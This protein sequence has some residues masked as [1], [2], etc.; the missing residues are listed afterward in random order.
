MHRHTQQQLRNIAIIAHVDHGKT[1]LVD[2]MLKQ[3]RTFAA[4]QKENQQTTI[5]DSNDLERERGVT[6]LAKNTAVFWEDYKINILDTPGHADFSGEVER[7]LN[8]ADGCVLLVDAAEGVLS[9]TRFVLAL[10]LQLGLVPIVV[11]NKVDRKDQRVA[12]VKSEID[13]LFLELATNEAQLSF[14]LLYA[15]GFEGI[16]GTQLAEQSDHSLKITNSEDLSPVF[17]TIIET[18][19]FPKGDLAGP[20]QLQVT[21]VDYD[22]YQGKY[23]IGRIV[24]GSIK[25]GQQVALLRSETESS[26]QKVK[27]LFTY[28]GLGREEISGAN[29]GE[30]IAITGLT[31]PKIGNTITAVEAQEILPALNISEPTVKVQL[32]VN[33]SPFVGREAEFSTSRQLQERLK[34][35]L[36]T[37]VGL[38]L[39]PGTTGE[40]VTLIGRGELHLSIL[41]ET[42]RREG[43]EF[44]LSRPEVVI[45][46]IDGQQ[47]E[48][49]EY[50]TIDAPEVRTGVITSNLAQRRGELVSMQTTQSGTRFTYEISTT[51]IIGLRN[52]LMTATSGE[53][54]L[55]SSF[56]A[57]RPLSARVEGGR[58]G[59]II[60]HET[61]TATAYSIEKAQ[62][63]GT[64]IVNPG[65]EVYAG[66]VVGIHKRAEDIVMNV[67]KG[68]KL[69]NMRA[70]SA[71]ATVVLAP[72][73]K[74]SLEQ[75][76]TLVSDD[77][78]LEV[79]P[80]NL[81]L[82]KIELNRK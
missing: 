69:T 37:N 77:E 10:A 12:A 74:P 53:A 62:D 25:Q 79:T 63:R 82:R 32:S 81:R 76:L 3:T 33:T 60:S 64:L 35:E 9:Q 45:K 39:E 66:Q 22:E 49:W 71:D 20:L 67:S 4:H 42:M 58:G 55:N 30:I 75:F 78:I 47:Q 46:E 72:A 5:M 26:I 18:V 31:E 29:V 19:P 73:W 7:V 8:M 2:S 38:K 15:R 54:V 41:V 11:I 14:P 50:L 57:Y 23:A 70:S 80:Q 43:Y 1:T 51:N 21:N 65:E 52:E 68:K 36:E 27:G 61:G 13:D 59:A 24:R 34:K 6:I 17:R 40:R 56:L 44:S 48:P 28:Y 16:S